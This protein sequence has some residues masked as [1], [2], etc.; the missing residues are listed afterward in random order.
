MD[1]PLYNWLQ[2]RE[3]GLLL[4]MSSL[5]SDTGI[6]NLGVEAYRVV[7]FLNHAR[8][9]IWQM[10]PL[11]PT[12]YGDSP[13][14]CF[15][16]FAGNPYFIDLVPL[17]EDGWIEPSELDALHALPSDHVDYGALY[18]AF[19]PVLESAYAR[20][21]S[22]GKDAVADYG[23]LSVFRQE[24]SFWLEDYA[25]F[26]ALKAKND[27]KCWL[28]WP[29]TDRDYKKAKSKRL[30]KAV[31]ANLD[32][33][34]FYQYVF[35]S[36]LAKLRRYAGE[37]KVAIMGDLPIFVALDSADVW[38]NQSLFQLD[39]KGYPTAVA[40]VPPDYFSSDGQ[41]WGNPLFEWDVHREDDFKWWRQRIRSTLDFYDIVR[42]DH[43]RGFESYWSVPAGESTARNG[44]WIKAPGYELF[45]AVHKEL[46]DAKIVAEDL[47]IITDEVRELLAAT[48]LPGMAVLHFAFSGEDDNAYLPHNIQPNTVVYTG[49]HDNDTTVGWYQSLREEQRDIVRRYLSVSGEHIAW[50]LMR[51]AFHSPA[52]LAVVPLQDL[53]CLG[54]DARLN[55]PGSAMGN[56]QWR[57]RP[58]QL[59]ELYSEK[60]DPL[61]EL[62]L[63]TRR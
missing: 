6:G 37:N 24:Q 49:T 19:W 5:P 54:S 7:D 12:G 9:K 48:G 11:G 20:F 23:S 45:E 25:R 4:H 39:D 30:T 40:G 57:Y 8:I 34:V 41:L 55:R 16:A 2:Q 15:S 52:N 3:S 21:Q 31:K 27:G 32:A 29:A 33:H 60:L 47:G 61:R 46:P 18:E 13:Y 35:Y 43:F 17:L 62:I 38:A 14:Q 26:M 58:E 44:T 50:D 28:D 63:E 42:I 53:L 36:Q 10:C 51:A 56:W 59:D 1:T 22:S